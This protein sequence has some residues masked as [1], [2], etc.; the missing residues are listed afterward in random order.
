MAKLIKGVNDLASV[1]PELIK[2]WCQDKNEKLTPEK[3][4]YGSNKVVWW[5]C[6]K[7]GHEWQASI[8]NRNSNHGCPVCYGKFAIAGINDLA[9]VR[10]DLLEEWDYEKNSLPPSAY[11]EK[12]DKKVWWKCK[13]CGHSWQT[14]IKYRSA[15]TNCPHCQNMYQSSFPEQALMFYVQKIYPESISRYKP[16]WLNNGEIDVYIPS[17]SIGIEY[18]GKRWHEKSIEKDTIKGKTI[19]EHHI[20]LIRI[21]EYGLSFLHD[22]SIQIDT[23]VPDSRGIYLESAIKQLIFYLN[24]QSESP[25]IDISADYDHI[26][27]SIKTGRIKDSLAYKRPDLLEEWDYDLNGSIRPDAFP[28]VSGFMVWW[29]CS[30]CGNKYKMTIGNRSVG[31]GCPKCAMLSKPQSK[32]TKNMIVGKNDMCSVHP[33]LLKEWDYNKNDSNPHDFTVGS[34]KRVWWKCETCGFSWIAAISDRCKGH[35]CPVCSKKRASTIRIRNLCANG[36]SF[37]NEHP[38]LLKE[39]D[40]SKNSM[41]PESI[42]SGSRIKVWWICSTCQYNWEAAIQSRSRGHGCP[43]C[44]GHVVFQGHTDFASQHPELI[45]EWD[46]KRNSDIQP[47]EVTCHSGRTVWWLCSKCGYSWKSPINRRSDGHGCPIC[48]KKKPRNKSSN[49]HSL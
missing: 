15:G 45:N 30:R 11:T 41:A 18:D 22:G 33:E 16:E 28:V 43:A 5:K 20:T 46:F 12:S 31:H 37:A 9:T 23:D 25:A 34:T 4:T 19:L 47:N 36:H 38:D 49:N 21:R 27:S 1:N 13:L 44:T 17:R 24:P 2:E 7:C 10:P 42:T 6:R 29:K 32:S 26:L 8:H 14:Q 40:Y 3:V 39:W 35:G 48:S